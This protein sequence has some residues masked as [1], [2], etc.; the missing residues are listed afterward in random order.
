MDRKKYLVPSMLKKVKDA[1]ENH[2]PSSPSL[3]EKYRPKGD[4]VSLDSPVVEWREYRGYLDTELAYHLGPGFSSGPRY[5]KVQGEAAIGDFG[6][7]D[8]PKKMCVYRWNGK[9]WEFVE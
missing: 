8:T 5:D 6:W 3:R 1:E 9:A 7:W 2:V 4:I